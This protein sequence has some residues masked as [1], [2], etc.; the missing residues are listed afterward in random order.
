MT[1]TFHSSAARIPAEVLSL[2]FVASVPDDVMTEEEFFTFPRSSIHHSPLVLGKVCRLWREISLATPRLWCK[3][4]LGDM[5]VKRYGY[6]SPHYRRDLGRDLVTLREW[7][8][9][10]GNCPL[11]IGLCYEEVGESDIDLIKKT[12]EVA[13][14]YIRRWKNFTS[15]LTP[16]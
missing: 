4:Q 12:I 11:S 15:Y 13:I 3:I 8:R 5:N 16:Q 9:R 1:Q 14:L 6:P 10:S 2:I 7:L